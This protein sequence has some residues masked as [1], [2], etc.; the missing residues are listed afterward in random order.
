LKRGSRGCDP[1]ED[2]LLELRC[3]HSGMG[4]HHQQQQATFA[5]R[6]QCL[7]VAFKS[8]LEWLRVLPFGML[9]RQRLHAIEHENE[10][11]VHGMFDPQSTVIV[12]GR[13]ALRRRN[14]VR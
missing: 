10:L 6:R 13:D 7:H 12:E 5:G 1:V 3:G 14:E 2:D 4:R 11:G 9:G 8:R